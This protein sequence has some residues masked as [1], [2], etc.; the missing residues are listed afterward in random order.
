[1]TTPN[2][3]LAQAVCQWLDDHCLGVDELARACAVEPRWVTEHV[4][5]G[6]LAFEPDS[7]SGR[8]H[9][10]SASLLRARRLAELERSFDAPPEI[11]ALTADLIEEVQRL[12][13]RLRALGL[14][15]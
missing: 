4:E 12:R 2:T 8:W 15:D 7:P 6:L 11:A 10:A 13:A 3:V 9:F 5:A 1:M 14:E